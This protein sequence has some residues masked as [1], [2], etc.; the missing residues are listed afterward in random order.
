MVMVTRETL[1]YRIH[2]IQETTA[3]RITVSD[4]LTVVNDGEIIKSY[5]D[6][7]PSP[8]RLMFAPVGNRPIHVVVAFDAATGITWLVTAYVADPEVWEADWKTRKP[9]KDKK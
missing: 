3:D 9:R 7:K 6:D 5:P 8:S 4:V 2:A 1:K